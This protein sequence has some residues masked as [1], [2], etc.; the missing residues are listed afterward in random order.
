MMI[1]VVIAVMQMRRK[2]SKKEKID[3][4]NGGFK[5]FRSTS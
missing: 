3:I 2:G 4:S 1:V 5:G